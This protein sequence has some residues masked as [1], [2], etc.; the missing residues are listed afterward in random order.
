MFALIYCY[1]IQPVA[2]QSYFI[3]TSAT[4]HLALCTC[5]HTRDTKLGP[6]NYGMERLGVCV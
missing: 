6:L 4:T 3:E 1:K 2:F 5:C